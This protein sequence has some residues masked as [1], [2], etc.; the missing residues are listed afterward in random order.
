MNAAK[1]ACLIIMT[2][3]GCVTAFLTEHVIIGVVQMLVPVL[4][5]FEWRKTKR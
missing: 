2:L 3:C 1:W 5:L 4:F